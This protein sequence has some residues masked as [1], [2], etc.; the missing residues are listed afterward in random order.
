M[1]VLVRAPSLAERREI[2]QK[3]PDEKDTFGWV[4][5]TCFHC[6]KEPKLSREQ[7]TDM[8]STKHPG[9]LVQ[10]SDAAWQ[11][12]EL[13]AGIVEREIR[14]LAGLVQAEQPAEPAK[15]PKPAR[16]TTRKAA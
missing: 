9:A 14:A 5:E 11:L 10:I 16:R 1:V 4:L 6:L 2:E 15:A 3:V 12:A 13:P 8:L 7:I